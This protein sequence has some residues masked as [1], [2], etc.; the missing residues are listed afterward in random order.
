M[1]RDTWLELLRA[2]LIELADEPDKRSR[3]SL[4]HAKGKIAEDPADRPAP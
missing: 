3:K 4:V 1:L 2:D